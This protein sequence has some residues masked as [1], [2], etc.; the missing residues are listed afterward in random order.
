MAFLTLI[1]PLVALTYCID[2]LNDG[3]AQGFNKW[4]REYIFNLLIQPMHLL[5]YFILVGSAM[6]TLGDNFIYSIVAIGFMLP[7]EKLL[8][9]LFGFEKAS[10]PSM[11]GGAAATSLMMSGIS[12]LTGMAGKG[13]KGGKGGDESGSG[14]GSTDSDSYRKD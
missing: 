11:L 7:A 9:S 1:S 6:S 8:R 14:S 3:S 13:S 12:K 10:T 2:K 4:F 5:L